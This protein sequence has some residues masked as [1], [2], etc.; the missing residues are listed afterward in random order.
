LNFF[1]PSEVYG[2]VRQLH[3]RAMKN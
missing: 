3:R 2:K 1:P